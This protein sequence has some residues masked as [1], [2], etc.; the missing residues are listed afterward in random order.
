MVGENNGGG[1]VRSSHRYHESSE[2]E[3]TEQGC[4]ELPWNSDPVAGTYVW[5]LL[6]KRGNARPAVWVHAMSTSLRSCGRSRPSFT[7]ILPAMLV[8][9]LET[10]KPEGAGPVTAQALQAHTSEI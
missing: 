6:P 9:A 10:G 3:L 5:S 4:G 7:A 1:G 2:R 8:G